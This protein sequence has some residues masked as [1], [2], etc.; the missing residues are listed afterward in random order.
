MF[1]TSGESDISS[2]ALFQY[3]NVDCIDQARC[4]RGEFLCSRGEEYALVIAEFRAVK[5][6]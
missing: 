3:Q 1:I 4:L 5:S 2:F 6:T